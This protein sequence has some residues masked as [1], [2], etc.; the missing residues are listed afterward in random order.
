MEETP[1]VGPPR[2]EVRLRREMEMT[3]NAESDNAPVTTS[4]GQRRP[5][6][7]VDRS[8]RLR[9]LPLQTL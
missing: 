1:M 9:R 7:L 2:R 6:R 4:P 8:S 3:G 5:A